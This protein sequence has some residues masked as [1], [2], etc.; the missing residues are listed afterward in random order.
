MIYYS[1]GT[2]PDEGIDVYISSDLQR[3]ISSIIKSVCQALNEQP[4]QGVRDVI[5]GPKTELQA[6]NPVLL[7]GFLVGLISIL[8]PAVHFASTSDPVPV[9]IYIPPAQ[10]SQASNAATASATI[11]TVDNT[12][13]FTVT[14]K[15]EPTT[16]TG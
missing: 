11:V 7:V 3:D 8:F 1:G 15:T 6:R 14:P 4:V 13:P 10:A 16:V 12:P 5:T 2:T 9:H